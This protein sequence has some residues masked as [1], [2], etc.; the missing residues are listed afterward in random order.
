MNLVNQAEISQKH[1]EQSFGSSAEESACFDLIVRGDTFPNIDYS[2]PHI[3]HGIKLSEMQLLQAIILAEEASRNG[4]EEFKTTDQSED[5]FSKVKHVD[6]TVVI[7]DSKGK[8]KR[9]Q[10][11]NERNERLKS[12][13]KK[14]FVRSM[15][16]AKLATNLLRMSPKQ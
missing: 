3:D 14:L 13:A 12:G 6:L 10:M 16:N 15:K 1:T 11:S 2:E 7:S 5:D 9:V 8:I 4:K